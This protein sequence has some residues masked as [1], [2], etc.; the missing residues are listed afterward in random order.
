MPTFADAVDTTTQ[1]PA[2][3][4]PVSVARQQLDAALVQAVAT[5]RG[6]MARARATG[7]N[8][9]LGLVALVLLGWLVGHRAWRWL[10]GRRAVRGDSPEGPGTAPGAMDTP[11]RTGTDVLL[12]ARA[13]AGGEGGARGTTGGAADPSE[14]WRRRLRPK[15]RPA[16]VPLPPNVSAFL[17][18]LAE[19][20]RDGTEA[21]GAEPEDPREDAPTRQAPDGDGGRTGRWRG[22][23]VWIGR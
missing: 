1:A 22:L 15:A 4:V 8:G 20:G 14:D 2:K 5:P 21:S 19:Q 10:R 13:G 17:E 12:D 7:W 11:V 9:A 16:P 3:H 18:R 23:D 6:F